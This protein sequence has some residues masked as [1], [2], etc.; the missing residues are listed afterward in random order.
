MPPVA[1]VTGASSGIGLALTQHLLS[2]SFNVAMLDLNPPPSSF[3]QSESTKYIRTDASN[4]DSLAS[5]FAQVHAWHSRLDFVALN[6]GID[7]RDDIFSSISSDAPPKK[8][9]MLTFEV[10]L[11]GPYYGMKLAAHYMSL[12]EVKGGKV[13]ITASAAALYAIPII[14]QYTATKAGLVGLTRA[15]APVAQKVNI[16]VN[17]ICPAVVATGLA[18]PGL[19]DVFQEQHITPMST[20]MRA[21]EELGDLDS[22]GKEGWTKGGKNGCIVEAS[23]GNLYYRDEVEKPD[24]GQEFMTRGAADTWTKVYMERNKNFALMDWEKKN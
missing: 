19:M 3:P 17:A 24:E 18:P 10:N 2:K 14:P 11:F 12:N 8:P 6:A 20:I 1:I 9:N 13:V 5:A 22:V 15:L 7:D 21:F 4:W 16:T 23:I